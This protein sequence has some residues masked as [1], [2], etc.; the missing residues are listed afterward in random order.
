MYSVIITTVGYIAIILGS[1]GMMLYRTKF[2]FVTH[3]WEDET[4]EAIICGYTMYGSYIWRGSW[5]LIIGGTAL[6]FVDFIG[7]KFIPTLFG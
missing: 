7:S 5:D 2:A 4:N 6:H 1:I 3:P